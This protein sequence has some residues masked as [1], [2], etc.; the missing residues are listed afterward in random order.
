I[1]TLTLSIQDI[2]SRISIEKNLALHNASQKIAFELQQLAS[3]IQNTSVL[4]TVIEIVDK[5]PEGVVP[6]IENTIESEQRVEL[7]N[8][9]PD[10][11]VVGVER[12]IEVVE[13]VEFVDSLPED[14]SVGIEQTVQID[15]TMEFVDNL[16]HDVTVGVESVVEI[17]ESVEFMDSLPVDV[18]VGMKHNFQIEETVEFVGSLPDGVI[19]GIESVVEIVET[20]EFVDSLPEGVSVGIEQAV[21]IEETVELVGSLPDGIIAGVESIVEIVETVE[22]VDSLPEGVVPGIKQIVQIDETV[23]LVDS[24]PDGVIV[25]VEIVV[26]IVETV[27]LVDS[28][29]EC[30]SAGIEQTIQ[31]EE[32][33]ELVDSLPDGVTAGV[34]NVVEIV[35]TVELVQSL[36][37]GVVV[38]IKDTAEI[39][40]VVEFVHNL[41]NGTI[42]GV[43]NVVQVVESHDFV[44]NLPENFIAD[45]ENTIQ[46]E[47]TLELVSSL[48]D[49]VVA[50]VESILETLETVEF[51]GSIPEDIF[52]GIE[53]IDD[54]VETIEL[55]DSLPDGIIVGIENIVE[56]IETVDFVDS[57]PEDF[58]I[59]IEKIVQIDETV[60]LV[61]SLPDGVIAGVEHVEEIVETVE[62]VDSLLEGF[63]VGIEETIEIK[64]TVELVNSLPEGVAA[65][66]QNVVQ[67]VEI[68]D[69]VDNL[70]DGVFVKIEDTVEVEAVETIENRTD[71]PE[72]IDDFAIGEETIEVDEEIIEIVDSL[73]DS[74]ILGVK[75]VV[76][77]SETFDILPA[78]KTFKGP[79]A[80]VNFSVDATTVQTIEATE[81]VDKLSRNFIAGV[82]NA[83][84]T[85]DI[86]EKL[87]NNEE[88][89]T[90]ENLLEENAIKSI[91]LFS[92]KIEDVETIFAI[93]ETSEIVDILPSGVI[94]GVER[95]QTAETVQYVESVLVDEID[96]PESTITVVN[97]VEFVNNMPETYASV[98]ETVE[99]VEIVE[100]VRDLPKDFVGDDTTVV[101]LELTE[102]SEL[103]DELP[104]G[105]AAGIENIIEVI[106]TVEVVDSLSDS[107]I[108]GEVYLTEIRETVHIVDSLPAAVTVDLADQSFEVLVIEQTVDFMDTLPSGVI[109]GVENT[110]KMITIVDSFAVGSN[111]AAN[112]VFN[113]IPD[114]SNVSVF[115][116]INIVQNVDL[117]QV[118]AVPNVV[119]EKSDAFQESTTET[120]VSRLPFEFED[121]VDEVF[122]E[123]TVIVEDIECDGT[124]IGTT[125]TLEETVLIKE[126]YIFD[127][128]NLVISIEESTTVEQSIVEFD[129]SLI[130]K[131]TVT[132]IE[133]TG[134][135][136]SVALENIIEEF[137][138]TT[139]ETSI[140]EDTAVEIISDLRIKLAER[141]VVPSEIPGEIVEEQIAQTKVD[142][143][144]YLEQVKLAFKDDEEAYENFMD[145][146]SD[147]KNQRIGTV[148]VIYCVIS[149]F[150]ENPSL[151]LNFNVFLPSGY[152][153]ELT[154]DAEDPFLVVTPRK[155]SVVSST[156]QT[157]N[158][159]DSISARIQF[160]GDREAVANLVA[161]PSKNIS[162]TSLI[163]A[164]SYLDRIKLAF[165]DDE[166]S[167]DKFLDTLSD[168]KHNRIGARE[169]IYR[170]LAI[171][172][173]HPSLA[174]DFNMFLPN[175]YRIDLTDDLEDPFFVYTPNR[176]NSIIS[177]VTS[178]EFGVFA[179][180]SID[181]TS[182]VDESEISSPRH[183]VIDALG[184]LN[185]V[186]IGTVEVIY[187]VIS[188]FFENPSLVLDFNIFLPNGYRI[189][190]TDDAEDPFFVITPQNNVSSIMSDVASQSINILQQDGDEYYVFSPVGTFEAESDMSYDVTAKSSSVIDAVG[191][192]DK[193]KSV[194]V[195]DS[196]LYDGFVDTMSDLQHQRIGVIEVIYRVLTVF[197]DQPSLAL[198]FNMF[199][200]P[201]YRIELTNNPQDPF[202]VYTPHR[203][204]SLISTVTSRGLDIVLNE[205]Y[206]VASKSLAGTKSNDVGSAF[207]DI[208]SQSVEIVS[209]LPFK[210]SGSVVEVVIEETV[211]VET[212]D[213]QVELSGTV[214]EM[215]EEHII[216]ETQVIEK[217]DNASITT[218]AVAASIIEGL[219]MD[220]NDERSEFS[221]QTRGSRLS[222]MD[223]LAYLDKV[224]SV[225]SKQPEVYD[226]FLDTM[227]EFKLRRISTVDVIHRILN[228][229]F[230]HHSLILEFNMFL[231]PGYYIQQSGSSNEFFIRTPHGRTNSIISDITSRD[232]G[233]SAVQSTY[234]DEGGR[235]VPSEDDLEYFE[236]GEVVVSSSESPHREKFSEFTKIWNSQQIPSDSVKINI[237][238]F[239]AAGFFSK[240]S[241]SRTLL[242]SSPGPV[243]RKG[244]RLL[245]YI[246]DSSSRFNGNGN[247]LLL[248]GAPGSGKTT[249]CQLLAESL[250][251]VPYRVNMADIKHT[252]NILGDPKN[253]TASIFAKIASSTS[254]G[255]MILFDDFDKLEDPTG[256]IAAT[257]LKILSSPEPVFMDEYIGVQIDLFS[258]LFVIT[259]TNAASLPN[260][261]T[262]LSKVTTIEIPEATLPEKVEIGFFAIVPELLEQYSLVSSNAQG[263]IDIRK[264]AISTL[265]YKFMPAANLT[266]LEKEIRWIIS[267]ICERVLQ[268]EE[269][270]LVVD[271]S[272]VQEF[273][274]SEGKVVNE[275]EDSEVWDSVG[276]GTCVW[277]GTAGELFSVDT[278]VT[279][280][281]G[282]RAFVSNHADSSEIHVGVTFAKRFLKLTRT[283]I[284]EQNAV[285]QS[286]V[287]VE[288][289]GLAEDGTLQA[290]TAF[291]VVANVL[292]FAIPNRTALLCSLK[293]TG[294][295]V[296]GNKASLATR[297]VKA[298]QHGAK[299]VILANSAKDVWIS[300]PVEIVRGVAPIFVK[301]FSELIA[302]FAGDE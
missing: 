239:V 91:K 127:T 1:K 254:A 171:L 124:L 59:G 300:V 115:E 221:V 280:A 162:R 16:P 108:E 88:F 10:G 97:R 137:T 155:H 213:T 186:K 18:I 240:S 74:V 142:P 289:A 89:D 103:V 96:D 136:I 147:L 39:V 109:I 258:T 41:P 294:A 133:S 278:M 168:L 83:K 94:P 167:Y 122:I 292:Q 51:V 247:V 68:V 224:K 65:G 113:V 218:D 256:E 53:N 131:E 275:I 263:N 283:A 76:V 295:I 141:E 260:S 104:T 54:I 251:L 207:D 179:E 188:A 172:F 296:S 45:V 92:E 230:E 114:N 243:G 244:S 75:G 297:I 84:Y 299:T 185:R 208:P 60:E 117:A 49:G 164:V 180:N 290:A 177:T 216:E 166:D 93:K 55:V 287:F 126:E 99:T 8:S 198:D 23:E 148:E 192:L 17:A 158:D 66:A 111:V 35:E 266:A 62:L 106:E 152:R 38:G 11:V 26:D 187:R 82:D 44:N 203:K 29:P 50:G 81:F 9:L 245:E 132:V 228:T 176:T 120:I 277:I 69:L 43:E 12:A 33:E 130:N 90:R 125:Y 73:P 175:G 178:K 157:F 298:C 140:T 102:S 194:F 169:V 2:S 101:Q 206:T 211:A 174:V 241:S 246:S 201:G 86:V 261:F 57:L 52:V 14:V 284:Y 46:I 154:D 274:H 189:E 160:S 288:T 112:E 56:I 281:D 161:L 34:E 118:A 214:V 70:P 302:A 119:T 273:M 87:I 20:V 217:N 222:V 270:V 121:G 3:T 267:Q 301:T 184:Y 144:T 72:D 79:A 233:A 170:V 7:V 19:A 286:R 61:S 105:E 4:E 36:P 28:L 173:E 285:G 212:V 255:S 42:A 291:A 77:T 202:L 200:P 143:F 257:L 205:N 236:I 183:S 163:D 128:E 196:E 219:S 220:I 250:E 48:P 85:K 58:A 139:V 145:T 110:E 279:E 165:A 6:G 181:V 15:E 248:A 47:R 271:D 25:S 259:T 276:L 153:I 21:Q 64:E 129:E 229:F 242:L 95:I 156:Y 238:T 135:D 80:I 226:K 232:F 264:S 13:T 209:E 32:T 116:A 215:V 98:L 193:I 204:N 138:E 231:P 191:Y 223:A 249:L 107:F 199:L 234:G 265:V 151:V 5:L 197:F 123:E 210:I 27:E 190:W 182:A 159:Q 149:A 282:E 71:F 22:L 195:N 272:N 24:L 237:A 252:S 63:V 253:H 78:S 150:F 100:I 30:V 293:L 227:S 262:G 37:D 269:L 134:T 235:V 268:D 225:F 31:I 40:E 67:I 146:L